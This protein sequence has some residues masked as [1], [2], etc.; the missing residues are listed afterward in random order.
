MNE[1]ISGADRHVFKA[2]GQFRIAE[3]RAFLERVARYCE[4]YD[5]PVDAL[6]T[7][8]LEIRTDLGAIRMQSVRGGLSIQLTAPNDGALHTLRETVAF[9][10]EM[11]E[12]D[13]QA[14]LDWH[15][16]I[17][18]GRLPP[19]FRVAQVVSVAALGRSFWRLVVEGD[20]LQPFARDGMHIRLALPA[21]GTPPRWPHLNE[22]GRTVWPAPEDLHVAVYSVR[23]FDV[24]TG[25]LTIDIFRH[26]GG[27][28]SDRVGSATRGEALGLIGPGGG[29]FPD[30]DHLV[31]AGDETALPAISR[32]LE[33]AGGH[34]I[35]TASVEIEGAFDCPPLSA[36]PGMTLRVLDRADG[37]SL[38]A[39]LAEVDLGAEGARHIWIAAEKGRCAAI[40]EDLRDRRGVTRRESY[41]T[42]YWQKT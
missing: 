23:D 38:E 13:C 7:G 31:I 37:S 22:R 29:W 42:G 2:S 5:L 9:Q 11:L 1:M 10:I 24:R 41:V 12:P 30:A 4:A 32:I 18:Q 3:P 34:V 21:R 28:T 19:N 33:N 6:R 14:A 20:D 36:P 25:R 8:A 35:G 16:E 17:A 27:R 15:G 26:A 39:A 40:R